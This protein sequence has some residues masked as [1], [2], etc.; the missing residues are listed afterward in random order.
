MLRA[1]HSPPPAPVRE[2]PARLL[3]GNAQ[4]P[5]ADVRARNASPASRWLRR[6]RAPYGTATRRRPLRS[7][8][9]SSARPDGSRCTRARAGLDSW[10]LALVRSKADL[11]ECETLR[12]IGVAGDADL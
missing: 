6:T 7:R 9:A 11:C 8:R 12:L 10:Y 5:S 1:S 3:Q 2:C 4:L